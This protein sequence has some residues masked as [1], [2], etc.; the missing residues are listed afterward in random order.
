MKLLFRASALILFSMFCSFGLK[1][2]DPQEAFMADLLGMQAPQ[3]VQ[4]VRPLDP[5]REAIHMGD[6]GTLEAL[7]R[8]QEDRSLGVNDPIR[9]GELVTEALAQ[10]NYHGAA[11]LIAYGADT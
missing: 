5:L 9:S 7:L 8:A 11:A 2:M 3:Y 6:M 10:R 4:P 1:A